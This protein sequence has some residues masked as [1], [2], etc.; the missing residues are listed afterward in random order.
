MPKG[1]HEFRL[2]ESRVR[3]SKKVM[4]R[5][6]KNRLADLDKAIN[7]LD[8]KGIQDAFDSLIVSGIVFRDAKIIE[9]VD[10]NRKKYDDIR[11][12]DKL[13][14]LGK[15]EKPKR[16]EMYGRNC[17]MYTKDHKAFKDYIIEKNITQQDVFNILFID[18]LADRSEG[19]LAHLKKCRDLE[20]NK[21]KKAVARL[22]NDKYVAALPEDDCSVILKKL[23][24]E[25]DERDF[26]E[27]IQEFLIKTEEEMREKLDED[28]LLNK[29]LQDKMKRLRRARSGK[30][31]SLA[32]PRDLGDD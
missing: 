3:K 7:D 11:I 28:E 12:Q 4:I 2:A 22:S 6:P 13:S 14:R 8:L 10:K 26:D 25:Y 9:F 29:E 15:A 1:K 27:S 31:S 30:I 24:E 21:R 23:T 5:F 32:Q 17:V 18:G 20:I 16:P 19:I